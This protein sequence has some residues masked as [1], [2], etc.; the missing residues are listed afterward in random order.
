MATPDRRAEALPLYKEVVE[1]NESLL[2]PQDRNTIAFKHNLAVTY[3]NS[4]LIKEAEPLLVEVVSFQRNHSGSN[5]VRLA[6]YLDSLATVY[7]MTG[8]LD[9]SV[10]LSEESRRIYERRLPPDNPRRL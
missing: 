10:A 1:L 3:I 6:V 8:Q 4:G 2:G 5:E 9:K 7:L